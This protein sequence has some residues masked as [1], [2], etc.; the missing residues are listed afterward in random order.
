MILIGVNDFFFLAKITQ[1][2][3]TLGV[4]ILVA[5]SAE[6]ILYQVSTC[7]PQKLLLDL[8]ATAC[9]PLE[10]IQKMKADPDSRS[11]EIVGYLSHVQKELKEAAL[12]AGCDR[13]LPRSTFTEKLA[14][15][16]TGE[17]T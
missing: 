13:V 2:A 10:I 3:K 7:K 11:I 15:L 9:R 6:E 14:E 4:P 5:K 1:T 12:E 8:N 17:G 16:L